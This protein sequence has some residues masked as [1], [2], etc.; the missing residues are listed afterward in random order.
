[1]ATDD[2]VSV[3][4]TSTNTSGAVKQKSFTYISPDATNGQLKAFA[5]AA[6]SLTENTYNGSKKVTQVNLDTADPG[7]QKQETTITLSKTSCTI[8]E[9]KNSGDTGSVFAQITTNSDGAL[10]VKQSAFTN[11]QSVASV[12]YTTSNGTYVMFF[13][14]ADH[15]GQVQT[16]PQTVTIYQAE[17]NTYKAASVDFT[18]TA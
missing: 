18:I 2:K 11:S 4:L 8:A 14:V 5:Q 10:F 17:S 7:Q 15:T 16:V 3:I 6:N 9:L 1:M 13:S 12:I